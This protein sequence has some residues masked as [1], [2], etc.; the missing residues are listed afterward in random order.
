MGDGSY[1][2]ILFREAAE[3][4]TYTFALPDSLEGK[5]PRLIYENAP[6]TVTLS[7]NTVTVKFGKKLSFVWVKVQ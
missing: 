4:D 2:L 3:E 6:T 7:D 5:K 1:H